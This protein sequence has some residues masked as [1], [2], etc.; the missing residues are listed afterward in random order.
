M[1][2]CFAVMSRDNVRSYAALPHAPRGRLL[3]NFTV[4]GVYC[5]TDFEKR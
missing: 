2:H 5:E 4:T 1:K 3:L